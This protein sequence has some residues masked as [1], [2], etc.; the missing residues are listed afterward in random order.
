M[1]LLILVASVM[2]DWLSKTNSTFMYALP[3]VTAL[4]LGKQGVSMV[5]KLKS[6]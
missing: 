1:A 2:I 4:I 3:F 5:E 6:K